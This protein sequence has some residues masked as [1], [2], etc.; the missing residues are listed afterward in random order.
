MRIRTRYAILPNGFSLAVIVLMA[1]N[2]FSTFGD[3]DYTWQIR[4]GEIIVESG[5]IHPRDHF[6]YTIADH[7]LPDFEWLWEVG[8][9]LTWDHFGYGGL[10]LIKTF[11]VASTLLLLAWRLRVAGLRW[12]GIALGL[13]I[14][15]AALSPAWNLRPLF[16]TTIGLLVLSGWLHDHATDCKPLSWWL[17][18]LM[19][20]WANCHPA[21]ITGQ[22]LLLGAIVWEWINRWVRVN[23]PLDKAALKRLTVIGGLG[24]LASFVGPDPVGR[25]RY[26]FK[27]ELAHP[28]QRVFVEMQP[29][30]ATVYK[31]PYTSGLVYVVAVLVGISVVLRFRQYRGWEI[32]LL[33]GLAVLANTAARGAQDW[34]L[35]M[36]AMGLPHLVEL[37]RKAALADRRRWWV[38]LALRC[39]STWKR[40]WNSPLLRCQRS[41]PLAAVALLF[42][43]SVIP[44]ISKK[45]PRQEA[46]DWPSAAVTYLESQGIHGNF[47]APPDYGTYLTW[48]L[49]DNAHCYA[50]TRGFYNLPHMIEDSHYVPQLGPDWQRRLDRVLND[51]PTDYFV[52]ETTGPRGELWRQLQPFIGSDALYLDEQT[53]VLRA[54]DVRTGVGEMEKSKASLRVAG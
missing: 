24:L 7:N 17:P 20:V 25:L 52:L 10:K 22:A 47:F 39:D 32:M 2:Y 49:G 45:M 54:K 28:I 33:M 9:W 12:H 15:V 30:Y 13:T 18:L 6:T 16:C 48:R 1:A 36:L 35:V 40:A 11:L 29:L 14:A 53:V 23:P 31:A 4:T 50:D 38:A 8:L 42:V 37:M 19:V 3:L 26:P 41:W 51:F 27:P 34:L 43:V 5:D 21:V 46:G 44:A